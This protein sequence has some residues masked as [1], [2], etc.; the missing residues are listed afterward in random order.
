MMKKLL[1]QKISRFFVTGLL[2]TGVT[3]FSNTKNVPGN[4]QTQLPC[5]EKIVMEC[6]TVYT[7]D[8]VPN[9]GHWTN[10]TS[11]PYN[12]TGSEQ[13]FEFTAPA[14]GLYIMDLDQGAGDADF[15]IMDDCSNTA[16]NVID[17]YWT[18]EQSEYIELEEGTT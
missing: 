13:V 10:Y 2:L 1:S 11:V 3:M 5:D 18:G 9:S 12:Y 7:A 8:L 15:M 17:F 16:G 4:S 6:D 14:S